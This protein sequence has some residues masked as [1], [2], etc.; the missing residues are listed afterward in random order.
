LTFDAMLA[1]ASG[2][3][4][5]VTKPGKVRLADDPL[6]IPRLVRVGGL[7]HAKTC[8]RQVVSNGSSRASY[9]WLERFS[10]GS[11]ACLTLRARHQYEVA[12]T[13]TGTIFHPGFSSN[14]HPSPLRLLPVLVEGATTVTPRQAVAGP[15]VE[16]QCRTR[17]RN[18]C[19]TVGD[20]LGARRVKVRFWASEEP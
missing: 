1:M 13:N 11:T 19:Q 18:K 12:F 20:R 15:E 6:A 17:C 2:S 4:A 16:P 14:A 9:R 8:S 10:D 3:R 7:V 5:T